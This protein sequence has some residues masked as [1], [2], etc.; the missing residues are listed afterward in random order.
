MEG[1]VGSEH[2]GNLF[3]D[4]V[5]CALLTVKVANDVSTVRLWD[6]GGDDGGVVVFVSFT[7]LFL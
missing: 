1:T 6:G 5:V 2:R 3:E 7:F 4:G